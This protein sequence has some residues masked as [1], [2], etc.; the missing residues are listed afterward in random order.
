VHPPGNKEGDRT[1]HMVRAMTRCHGG[2]KMV[3][4]QLRRWLWW[5]Y[6]IKKGAYSTGEGEER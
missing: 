4:S 6:V 1:R 5:S 2:G 3:M